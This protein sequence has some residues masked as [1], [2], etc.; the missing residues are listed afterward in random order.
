VSSSKAKTV[1]TTRRNGDVIGVV[2][3]ERAC[4]DEM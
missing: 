4:I 1:R 3:I 2:S